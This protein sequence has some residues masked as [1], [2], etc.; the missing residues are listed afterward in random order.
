[1]SCITADRVCTNMT[2]V[3]RVSRGWIE[4]G[5][6]CGWT[7]LLPHGRS[8]LIHSLRPISCILWPFCRCG[9]LL[10]IT[11]VGDGFPFSLPFS[12]FPWALLILMGFILVTG[13]CFPSP[14]VD[15]FCFGGGNLLG[16]LLLSHGLLLATISDGSLCCRRTALSRPCYT[17]SHVSGSLLY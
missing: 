1:M 3:G 14:R 7:R 5:R 13:G 11:C 6:G 12:L 17:C 9:C 15:D 10:S 2:L 16:W 4:S 8:S